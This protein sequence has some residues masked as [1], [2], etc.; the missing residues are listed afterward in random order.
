MKIIFFTTIFLIFFFSI[1]CFAQISAPGLGEAKTASWFAI[2]IKQKLDNKNK[3]N[4][5]SYIGWGHKSNP[6]NY[7]PY[8]KPA[9]FAINQE[10]YYSFA[11]NWKTSIAL[12]YRKSHEYTNEEPFQHKE[13]RFK[14][15]FRVYSRLSYTW[16]I[17]QLKIEST[18]RQEFRK[19]YGS[20]FEELTKTSQLRSRFRLKLKLNL[21]KK[22]NHAISTS[23]ESI[24]TTNKEITTTTKWIKFGYN[25]SRFTLYYSY[26]LPKLPIT[27]SIGY[28]N[29]LRGSNLNEMHSVHYLAL[30]IVFKNLFGK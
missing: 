20:N 15:E 9:L 1:N 22:N 21:D 5:V 26:S 30:D 18:A 14:Q 13:N 2:G 23:L 3:L 6:I 29:N 28:M 4:S 25:E 11:K 10:F 27:T 12:S 8:F 16:K 17:N 24:F 7:N 19:F